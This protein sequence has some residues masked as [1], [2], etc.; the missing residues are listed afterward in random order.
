MPQLSRKESGRSWRD[1]RAEVKGR[2]E[3]NRAA[4]NA[5]VVRAAKKALGGSRGSRSLFL[6]ALCNDM[7]ARECLDLKFGLEPV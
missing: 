3:I 6:V 5:T 4:S 7:T 2:A 1:N